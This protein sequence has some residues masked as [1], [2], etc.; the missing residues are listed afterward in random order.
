VVTH[1]PMLPTRRIELPGTLATLAV[2]AC[3]AVLAPLAGLGCGQG[4]GDRC[5]ID[6]D[7]AGSRTC[8]LN[9][10]RTDGVCRSQ[11]SNRQPDAAPAPDRVNPDVSIDRPVDSGGVDRSPDASSDS[12]ADGPG[13]L[14][15]GDDGSIDGSS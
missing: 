10:G 7:C 12:A 5:E 11:V 3:L 13:Q 6:S 1:A 15:A 4:E 9:R 14:D 8:V 2:V